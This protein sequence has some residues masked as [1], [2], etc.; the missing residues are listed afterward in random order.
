T[1]IELLGDSAFVTY[2]ILVDNQVVTTDGRNTTTASDI[3]AILQNLPDGNHTVSIS[4]LISRALPDN[5]MARMVFDKAIIKYPVQSSEDRFN[6]TL[7]PSNNKSMTL[8]EG[9]SSDL[10]FHQSSTARDKAQASFMG[11]SLQNSGTLLPTGGNYSVTLDNSTY[12]YTSRSSFT[13]E[14]TLLFH[15]GGLSNDT[16]HLLE[17]KNEGGGSLILSVNGTTTIASS[18]Q[19]FANTLDPQGDTNSPVLPPETSSPSRSSNLGAI[20]GRRSGRT[21]SYNTH[22]DRGGSSADGDG[23]SKGQPITTPF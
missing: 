4:N 1:H 2:D 21:R 14:N 5:P 13:D 18:N 12:H 15:V 7:D 11:V 9:W 16:L 6:V 10:R 19:T 8:T 22:G 20:L 17:I 23:R 3:L